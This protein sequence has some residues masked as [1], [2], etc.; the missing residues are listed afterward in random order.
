MKSIRLLVS[1]AVAMLLATASAFPQEANK[2]KK[3]SEAGPLQTE[4]LTESN[5]TRLSKDDSVW[6]DTKRKLVVVDGEVAIR[7]GFLEMFACP[8]GT[9]EHESLVAVYSKAYVVHTG[10]LAVGAVPGQ[11]VR[12]N[13]QY[14]P[15]EGP[16]IDIYVLWR[17]SKGEKHSVRAQEWVRNTKTEKQMEQDWVFGGSGF[18]TDEETGTKH[19]Y[20]EQGDLICLS[21][22]GTAMLD[23]PIASSQSDDQLLFEAFTERV[24]PKGTKVRLVLIPR[25]EKK[26]PGGNAKPAEPKSGEKMEESR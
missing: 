9:K 17:D 18:W 22:F 8:Q 20:A 7:D 6:I 12:F 25:Q 2:E 11:P 3:S 10:L 21:N 24:P 23:V 26:A 19:Y 1:I 5:L 16:V 15:V 13:P 4:A 14:R